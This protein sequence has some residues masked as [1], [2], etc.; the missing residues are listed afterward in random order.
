[1]ATI[2]IFSLFFCLF[3]FSVG[4]AQKTYGIFENPLKDYG[5]KVAIF[6]YDSSLINQVNQLKFDQLT[7]FHLENAQK[8]D[9][10]F[11]KV[12]T[13]SN[14]ITR[15]PEYEYIYRVNQDGSR[16]KYTRNNT[17]IQHTYYNPQNLIIQQRIMNSERKEII[18]Y[19]PEKQ[20]TCKYVEHPTGYYIY[21]NDVKNRE[22]HAQEYNKYWNHLNVRYLD[23]INGK[24]YRITQILEEMDTVGFRQSS[25]DG[26]FYYHTH[27]WDSTS[28]VSERGQH[29][30]FYYAEDVSPHHYEEIVKLPGV[31]EFKTSTYNNDSISTT[32]QD[33]QL[34]TM[35][36]RNN[37]WLSKEIEYNSTPGNS[38]NRTRFEKNFAHS[39]ETDYGKDVFI[40]SKEHPYQVDKRL[41]YTFEELEYDS[42]HLNHQIIDKPHRSV[43]FT[44]NKFGN[45]KKITVIENGEKT[46]SRQW[47]N[48]FL[49]WKA[50]KARL[51]RRFSFKKK[52][53]S[54]EIYQRPYMPIAELHQLA[55]FGITTQMANPELD[56]MR[57]HVTSFHT[58]SSSVRLLELKELLSK[59]ESKT[60]T[61]YTITWHWQNDTCLI[62]INNERITPNQLANR[63]IEKV[64]F[65]GDA[66]APTVLPLLNQLYLYQPKL[67]HNCWLW[68]PEGNK[69]Q[70]SALGENLSSLQFTWKIK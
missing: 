58:D 22:L 4:T 24:A 34:I 59:T 52:R 38:R 39:A 30:N 46:V 60:D 51:K 43:E 49:K 57:E 63:L 29:S 35:H 16:Y 56:Y 68:V 6:R 18:E 47:E 28:K 8:I 48:Y 7:A 54:K 12:N 1:M 37:A 69:Q 25:L 70:F 15:Y 50:F 66:S 61:D 19:D 5:E 67:M 13:D 62:T 11:H 10:I 41:F 2:R 9:T 44:Y 20:I 42:V 14:W 3:V 17:A 33:S 55:E 36:F 32:T 45:R 53:L 31:F 26:K 65:Y 64:R 27:C 21:E 40:Y 23:T